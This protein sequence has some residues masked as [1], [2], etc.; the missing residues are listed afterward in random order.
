MCT[1]IARRFETQRRRSKKYAAH[2]AKFDRFE[3]LDRLES[4]VD[5]CDRSF[6]HSVSKHDNDWREMTWPFLPIIYDTLARCVRI[7]FRFRAIAFRD[8]E[9]RTHRDAEYVYVSYKIG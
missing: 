2:E 1:R 4:V 3:G 7:L 8:G 9:R 6:I 5:C